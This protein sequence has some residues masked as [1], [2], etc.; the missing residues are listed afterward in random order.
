MGLILGFLL[1]AL[2]ALAVQ[3]VLLA[4]R[5]PTPQPLAEDFDLEV[6]LRESLLTGLARQELQRIELDQPLQNV[7]VDAL[8]GRALRL[9]GQATVQGT[10]APV[11]ATLEPRVANGRL[12]L[13]IV[14]LQLG[15]TRL[16]PQFAASIEQVL[17]ERLQQAMGAT[18]FQVVGVATD[19]QSLVLQLREQR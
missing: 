1:G 12:T 8:P 5:L 7:Q 3:F 2:V 17:N 9:V 14:E 18:R 11:S 13:E 19:E 16:P 10:Q 4:P 6:R 15:G